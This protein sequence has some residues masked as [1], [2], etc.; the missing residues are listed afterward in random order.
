[1]NFTGPFNSYA[2]NAFAISSAFEPVCF[3][4]RISRGIAKY[5]Q[6]TPPVYS[7]YFVYILYSIYSSTIHNI[8]VYSQNCIYCIYTIYMSIVKTVG[9]QFIPGVL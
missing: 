4:P 8:H 5:T 7:V 6:Y 2:R 9:S 1:V 3:K